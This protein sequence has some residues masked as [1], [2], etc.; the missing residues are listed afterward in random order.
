MQLL[1]MKNSSFKKEVLLRRK[2]FLEL[3][4]FFL[5]TKEGF[6]P[7]E[8]TYGRDFFMDDEYRP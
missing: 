7:I 3:A 8:R 6:F 4:L 5:Y 2:V 1:W